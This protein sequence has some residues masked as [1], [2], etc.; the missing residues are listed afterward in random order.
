[1]E[2]SESRGSVKSTLSSLVQEFVRFNLTRRP[3]VANINTVN[4][5][6]RVLQSPTGTVYADQYRDGQRIAESAE[7]LCES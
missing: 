5:V 3:S 4:D 1:M 2:L 6:A 7:V